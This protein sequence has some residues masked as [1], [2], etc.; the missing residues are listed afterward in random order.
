MIRS[1]VV[2]SLP[3]R[4]LLLLAILLTFPPLRTLAESD[5]GDVIMRMERL[6]REGRLPS[7][8]DLRMPP[9]QRAEVLGRYMQ[10]MD[11]MRDDS[12]TTG[13]VFADVPEDS[14]YALMSL[15]QLVE[16]ALEGNF[17]LTNAGRNLEIARSNVIVEEAF[18]TPFVDLVSSATYRHNRNDEV[19]SRRPGGTTTRTTDSTSVGVGLDVTQNLPT[20]GRLTASLDETRT[21]IASRDHDQHGTTSEWDAAAAVRLNQPLLRGSGLLTGEGTDIGTA[22]L[23][24]ARLSEMRQDLSY[25]LTRRDTIQDVIRQYFSILTARRQLLVSRDAIRE[26]YR[27]LDETRIKYEVGRVAESEILR[28]EIQFLE[29]IE[30]AINRQESLDNARDQLLLTVGLPLDTPIS[31]LDVTEGL[32]MQ[33]RL[34][35]P[36]VET[37]IEYAQ[38][39]RRELLLA[40]ID[41]ELARISQQLARNN[42]LPFLD[43]TTGYS[44]QGDD[45]RWQEANRFGNN[46][47]DAGL[48]LRIPLQNIRERQAARQASLRLENILTDRESLDRRLTREVM[49]AHRAVLTNEARLTVLSK[50]VEQARRNLALINESFEVGFSTIT[51]VRIAQDDLFNAQSA[52]STAVLSYQTNLAS[53]YVAMGLPLY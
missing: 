34:E 50:R 31:L 3:I 52:F 7:Y 29:E 33:G 15:G 37:A 16:V 47:Y 46:T 32:M 17:S 38:A 43:F 11:L 35:I 49:S 42:L 19:P 45:A 28:A 26:R 51:E 6:A 40:D 39:H 10:S 24:R 48:A 12:V 13:V 21:R 9:G 8:E 14:P 44:W 22:D 5:L 53:L 23:R 1:H 36:D 25:L 27:F 4:G 41:I 18:F 2:R 30:R 20:A